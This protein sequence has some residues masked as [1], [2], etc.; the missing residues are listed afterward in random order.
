[1]QCTGLKDKNGKDIYEGDL[2]KLGDNPAEIVIW[3]NNCAC[4]ETI[5]QQDWDKFN[6]GEPLDCHCELGYAGLEN[7]MLENIEIVGNIYERKNRL[8]V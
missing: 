3:C 2:I 5:N 6:N 4:Y 8:I 7:N 1:M